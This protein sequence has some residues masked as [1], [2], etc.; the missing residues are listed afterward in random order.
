M[1][2][3][4]KNKNYKKVTSMLTDYLMNMT[5]PDSSA[6]K[7]SACNAGD[8]GSIS[9]LGRSP[10]GGHGNPLQCS[11]LENSKDR[12][13]WQATVHG[14]AKNRTRLK[15]SISG[16]QQ[17]DSVIHTCVLSHSVVFHS[18]QPSWAA[19]HKAPLSLGFSRQEYCHGLPFPS[20]GDLPKPEIKFGSPALAGRFFT[21]E[22]PGKP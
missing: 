9:G 2:K 6:G 18:L 10:G 15:H 13:A 20:L 21:T 12:G 3:P 16:E 19:A 17:R 4:A 5:F 11:C 8:P 22:P 1:L 14:V 7:E